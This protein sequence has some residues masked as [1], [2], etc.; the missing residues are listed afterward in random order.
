[1][2][3]DPTRYQAHVDGLRAIAVLVV[4]LFHLEIG[5]FWGGFVGVDVFLVI[6]G[7]LITRL[8]VDEVASTGSFRYGNFYLRRIRRLAP[9][10]LAVSLATGL[11]GALL[12]SP[13]M[14]SRTAKEI[15]AGLLS[16]SNVR[17]WLEADY[18]DVS[19]NTK[20]MLHTWSL[21]LEEQFYLL[22]PAFLVLLLRGKTRR[23]VPAFLAVVALGSL[24]LNPLFARGAPTWM[25]PLLPGD[26]G[27]AAAEGKTTIFYLLPF[28]VFE[29]IC[30]ALLVWI[31][32]WKPSQRWLADIGLGLGLVMIAASTVLFHEEML[33]PSF[34]A[35]V[36]CI[37]AALAIHCGDR[38]RIHGLLTNRVCVGIGLISYSLYLV[39][40]PL[41]VLWRYIT[42][43][44]S[45]IDQTAI[46]ALSFC[47][48]YASYR[49]VERPFRQR[50]LPLAP[51]AITA[52]AI[53]AVAL[54]IVL[55]H[56]W[57][58]RIRPEIPLDLS[59][60]GLEYR[61]T[62]FGGDG[63]ERGMIAGSG[64]P[65]IILIG[66]SH[67]QHCAEGMVVELARPYSLALH[68]Q[69]GRSC[70]HLPGIV[71]TTK[72][73]D[74]RAAREAELEAVADVLAS[75]ATPPVVVVA[76]SW[77][78]QMKRS[79]SE[80]TNARVTVEEIV[81][82]LVQL[83]E[84]LGVQRLVVL[85]SVPLPRVRDLFEELTRPTLARRIQ[86]ADAAKFE[87]RS[88]IIALNRALAEGAVRTG[89][90]EFLDPFEAL[91]EDGACLAI[92][93]SGQLLFSDD[94]HLSKAGS[95]RLIAHFAARL[96]SLVGRDGV[97]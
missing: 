90:Y 43:T 94:T 71:R 84:R 48:A 74:W 46:I 24:I 50:S 1:M 62:H 8:I 2:M 73:T 52:S 23:V 15:I 33:F 21:S 60:G 13:E 45:P 3:A 22:W 55:S 88:D 65:D 85:G 92:D 82:G 39:H 53:I 11:A 70:L 5:G 80:R 76:H 79:V 68:M 36:P 54:H 17:F 18:F 59:H 35:L 95:R 63:Y 58:W 72:G 34:A 89:A 30:G 96:A 19:A 49:F 6:S 78:G 29:F 27:E 61:R 44:L 66:D 77:I 64:A 87:L 41:I 69:A 20:P 25:M 67:A 31:V 28:R 4:L 26:L 40:W 7:Y 38:S 37:G 93:D 47:L 14:L 86:V 56:G 51:L 97:P 83:K 57:T 9:A 42:G 12:C 81:D 32:R 75:C 16:Y 91:S 10:L